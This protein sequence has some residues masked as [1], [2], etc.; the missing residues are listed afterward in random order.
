[1]ISQPYWVLHP[2]ITRKSYLNTITMSNLRS[3]GRCTDWN[4]PLKAPTVHEVR[5]YRS[6]GI[7]EGTA[8]RPQ[9]HCKRTLGPFSRVRCGEARKFERVPALLQCEIEDG[10][11]RKLEKHEW[12]WSDYRLRYATRIINTSRKQGFQAIS[13]ST[14]VLW[15]K[16]AHKIYRYSVYYR[17]SS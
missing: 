15:V 9:T 10:I 12:S 5:S 16:N 11:K 8:E 2:R 4:V 7:D 1:M 17:R 3:R 13:S 14:T 6:E